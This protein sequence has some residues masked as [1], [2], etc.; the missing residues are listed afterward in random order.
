MLP[1]HYWR[2][3]QKCMKETKAQYDKCKLKYFKYRKVTGL[4]ILKNDS[5]R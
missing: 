5:D 3:Y 2:E 4:Y 1:H